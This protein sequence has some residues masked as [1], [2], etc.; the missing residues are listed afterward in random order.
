MQSRGLVHS[1]ANQ[2]STAAKPSAENMDLTPWPSDFAVLLAQ[3]H[4]GFSPQFKTSQNYPTHSSPA[5]LRTCS[6][7]HRVPLT[8]A[9]ALAECSLRRRLEL[10]P[11]GPIRCAAAERRHRVAKSAR[12]WNTAQSFA[13]CHSSSRRLATPRCQGPNWD[14]VPGTS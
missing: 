12:A 6:N 13:A 11:G 4:A 9:S 10:S 14:S 1:S 5:L 7:A 2:P 8:S 3:R